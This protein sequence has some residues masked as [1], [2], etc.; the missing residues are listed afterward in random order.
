MSKL[1][2]FPP[3]FVLAGRGGSKKNLTFLESV[4]DS[5]FAD[6]IRRHF[7]SNSVANGKADKTFAH[8]AGDVREH[9]MLVSQGNPEH[10][11]R[12]HRHNS[13]FYGNRLFRIHSEF[14]K[15]LAARP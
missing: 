10:G 14:V 8:F 7:H 2:T 6:I 13:A 1:F 3:G 4:D 15:P 12:Q 9:K 11:A 5:G